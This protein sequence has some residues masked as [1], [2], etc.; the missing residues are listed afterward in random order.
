MT[1]TLL[2]MTQASRTITAG[3]EF[4]DWIKVFHSAEN[5]VVLRWR[6]LAGTTIL[7]TQ[8]KRHGE[9][10]ALAVVDRQFTL[11]NEGAEGVQWGRISGSWEVRA[12]VLS[13][14]YDSGT[15]VVDVFND[16][17]QNRV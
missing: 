3:N 13:G 8:W 10:D 2:G 1:P 12:G 15:L 7:S 4:T 9:V 17:D 6:G 5:G 14:E 16:N 11:A